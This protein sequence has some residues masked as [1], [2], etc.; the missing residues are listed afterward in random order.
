MIPATLYAGFVLIESNM[1]MEVKETLPKP[2][3]LF[4]WCIA[5]VFPWRHRRYLPL[6]GGVQESVPVSTLRQGGC[7]LLSTTSAVHFDCQKQCVY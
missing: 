3:A 1:N 2:P 5:A 7:Q 6:P 4:N